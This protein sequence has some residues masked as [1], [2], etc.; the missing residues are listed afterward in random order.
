MY[1]AQC[2]S[3]DSSR[4]A[5]NPKGAKMDDLTEKLRKQRDELLDFLKNEV[6]SSV[7]AGAPPFASTMRIPRGLLLCL[8]AIKPAPLLP[9]WRKTSDSYIP[10]CV[11]L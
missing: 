2:V 8:P 6:L 1:V 10:L 9:L 7:D 11:Y 3:T 5:F 4:W